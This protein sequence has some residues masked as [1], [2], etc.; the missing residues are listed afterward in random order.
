MG[1]NELLETDLAYAWD[2]LPRVSRSFAFV[3]SCLNEEKRSKIGMAVMV[4]YHICRVLDTIEDSNIN[5]EEKWNLYDQFLA[6]LK[7]NYSFDALERISTDLSDND[8]YV[9]LMQNL[10][11]IVS[12][13]STLDLQ[14][15]KIIQ[16]YAEEMAKG[17]YQF[18]EKAILTFQD[19][20]EYC[21][22]VAGIVG[23][24]LTE[25]F[26]H[27][28]HFPVLDQNILLLARHFGLALQ[29]VNIIRDFGRD[30]DRQVYFWPATLVEKFELNYHQLVLKRNSEAAKE[31]IQEMIDQS[32]VDMD[33]AVR[34]LI[35]IPNREEKVRIFCGVSLLLALRTLEKIRDNPQILNPQ[36]HRNG[37]PSLKVSR[38][39]VLKLVQSIRENVTDNFFFVNFYDSIKSG[40]FR[41]SISVVEEKV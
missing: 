6:S 16:R 21:H 2:L 24:G 9:E 20:D 17:M 26:Y 14:A 18:G 30:Y 28:G 23:Y 29:K 11:R 31:I 19:L 1:K 5:N 40:I 36:A 38:Q 22:P 15:K 4:F 33:Q 37:D 27:Y 8:G 7:D 10:R 34:Y 32:Q 3:T 39:E 12:V 25:L 13:Y 35:K 41:Q